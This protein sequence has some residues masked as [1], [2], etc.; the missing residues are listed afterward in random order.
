[1]QKLTGAYMSLLV[2]HS[3]PVATL[4]RW[5]HVQ[6]VSGMLFA[7]FA[8]RSIFVEALVPGL[9]TDEHAEEAT[10]RLAVVAAGAG[11][12]DQ[13]VEHRARIAKVKAW[14]SRPR[15]RVQVAT[16]FLM[17]RTLGALTYY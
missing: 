6:T 9:A 8:C 16:L 10:G 12:E 15:T 17:L 7:G 5:T 11:E 3:M 13:A 2:G 1:M 14:L 4:S